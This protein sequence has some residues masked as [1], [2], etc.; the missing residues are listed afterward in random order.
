MS[1]WQEWAGQRGKAQAQV[2]GTCRDKERMGSEE[3]HFRLAVG[4]GVRCGEARLATGLSCR[5]K[6]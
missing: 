2:R 6:I 4:V 3:T 1:R 5:A